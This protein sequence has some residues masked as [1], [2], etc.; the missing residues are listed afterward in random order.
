MATL[1]PQDR[2]LRAGLIRLANQ[3]PKG[4][5]ERRTLLNIVTS[6]DFNPEEIG[7]KESGP[8]QQEGD[9]PYMKG[10]FQQVENTELHDKQ[11]AGQLPSVDKAAAADRRAALTGSE[12][13]LFQS[14][15]RVA[16][17]NADARGPILN[18]LREAGLIEAGCEKLPEG[19]MRDMCEKKK[20][21]GGKDEE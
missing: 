8:L 19:K 15:V 10:E 9:E 21:E 20:E 3:H 11:Q 5:E 7:E 2:E 1:S 14:L 16:H 6:A 4:S 12:K 18:L 17:E 13:D